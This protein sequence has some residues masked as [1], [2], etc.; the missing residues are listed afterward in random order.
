[1]WSWR[2]WL[3][4]CGEDTVVQVETRYLVRGSAVLR[5]RGTRC[6]LDFWSESLV[7]EKVV[8]FCLRMYHLLL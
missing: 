5:Q 2:V 6:R 3:R 8:Q 4:L 7:G 1:M